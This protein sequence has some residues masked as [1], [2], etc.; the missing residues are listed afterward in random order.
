MADSVKIAGSAYI[1]KEGLYLYPNEDLT[2][3][4]VLTFINYNR[5]ITTYGENYRYYT[6]EHKILK[7][8]FD[9]KS[10]RPDNRVISNWANYVVDTYIGYFMGTPVK[11]QL[12]DDSKNGLLQN[13]LKIN[14]FQ[15]KL[16]EAAKQVA[17]Y[18]LSYMLA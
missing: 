18:G 6:G 5:G 4:D 8:K 2:G 16:S 3:E 15:D 12:E 9:P 11:I 14:T 13:W 1:S 10:F 17:I 7:K